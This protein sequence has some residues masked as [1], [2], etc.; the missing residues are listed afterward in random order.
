MRSKEDRRAALLELEEKRKLLELD[1]AAIC[2][3]AGV[4]YSTIFR[5]LKRS[6]AP[7]ESTLESIRAALEELA[8]KRRANLETFKNGT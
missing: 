1:W 7:N 2:T 5:C 6:Q 3:Q 8:N 4:P